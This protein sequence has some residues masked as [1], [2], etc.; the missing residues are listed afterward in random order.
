LHLIRILL[1]LPFLATSTFALTVSMRTASGDSVFHAGQADTVSV[2]VSIDSEAE[3]VTGIEIF[4]A[5]DPTL[6]LPL[7]TDSETLGNQPARSSGVFG[8]VFADSIIIANGTTSVIHFAEVD[9]IGEALNDVVFSV[10]FVL[11]DQRSGASSIRVLQ[12]LASGFSSLYTPTNQDGETVVIPAVAAVTYQDLAPVLS[13]LS[14]F[15][16]EEDAG[17]AFLLRDVADDDGGIEAL[18]FDVVFDDSTAGAVVDG[19][20]LRFVTPE[21]YNGQVEGDLSVR[22]GA[23]GETSGPI[24]LTVIPVND[25]P[26]IVAS[27]LPDTVI[28]GTDP[29]VLSLEGSDVDDALDDLLW[30]ALVDNDS[31]SAVLSDTTLTLTAD[32]A[33]RGGANVTLQLADPGGLVDFLILAIVGNAKQGDFDGNDAVDFN[34]FLMFA[35]A[36]G[37][38]DADPRFDLDGNGLVDFPDFLIFVSNFGT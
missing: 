21:N 13:G 12:D 38:P 7:D 33:W 5:Y 29:V 24:T 1:C 18:T 28:L 2:D 22:D 11:V 16:I 27:S 34:D 23:G 6:Y 26:E 9:L 8:Q 15:T 35:S 17:P 4:L 32:E 37:N 20:S 31:V 25:S 36:F 19:D 30:F 14:S 10:Q 3:S